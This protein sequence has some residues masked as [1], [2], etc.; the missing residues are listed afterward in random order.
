MNSGDVSSRTSIQQF[1][2]IRIYIRR[3]FGAGWARSELAEHVHYPK[4]V[5]TGRDGAHYDCACVLK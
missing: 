2:C 1:P 5:I 3:H 4:D